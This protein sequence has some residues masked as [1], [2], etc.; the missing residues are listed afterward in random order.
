MAI[1]EY[2][3]STKTIID[4]IKMSLIQSDPELLKKYAGQIRDLSEKIK[5]VLKG[6]QQLLL[7]PDGEQPK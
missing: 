1:V 2:T 7:P 4:D 6:K 5:D 3:E